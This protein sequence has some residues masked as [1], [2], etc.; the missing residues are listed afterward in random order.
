MKLRQSQ[1][2]IIFIMLVGILVIGFTISIVMK[3]VSDIYNMKYNETEVSDDVYQDFFTRSKT[4][5][6]WS[7]VVIG[8]GIFIWGL[9]KANQ[10]GEY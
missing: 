4:V 3:P 1:A 5:W 7:P 10:Q 6:V 8:I 9:I 2:Y